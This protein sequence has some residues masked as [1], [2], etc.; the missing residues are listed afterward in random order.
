MRGRTI[1][2]TQDVLNAEAFRLGSDPQRALLDAMVTNGK[3]KIYRVVTRNDEHF[4]LVS[5]KKFNSNKLMS[6]RLNPDGTR[7]VL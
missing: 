3:W 2:V 6:L 4:I 5:Q 1:R 7:D